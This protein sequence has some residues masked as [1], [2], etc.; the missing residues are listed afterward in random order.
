M[1]QKS[2][3][4]AVPECVGEPRIVLQQKNSQQKKLKKYLNKNLRCLLVEKQLLSTSTKRET[5]RV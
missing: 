1:T 4:A 3:F 2:L 5:F